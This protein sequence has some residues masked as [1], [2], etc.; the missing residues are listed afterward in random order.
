MVEG[1]AAQQMDNHDKEIVQKS[2]GFETKEWARGV[3]SYQVEM[4]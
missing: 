2:D 4:G 1:H 3:G